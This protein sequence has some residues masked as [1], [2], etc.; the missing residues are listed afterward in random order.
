MSKEYK[1]LLGIGLG[2]VILAVV[3]FKFT[4]QPTTQTPL[5]ERSGT[6]TKG[7]STARV[8]LTEFADFQCPACRSAN[9]LSSQ[10]LAAYPND[11]KFVFRHFPLSGHLNA[12]I[13]AQAAEAAGAQGKFWEMHDLLY[14]KQTE[15]GNTSEPLSRQQAL[16]TFKGYAG[17]LGLDQ[18]AFAQAVENNSSVDVINQDMSA[19]S[20]S[21]VNSTPTFFV[22][23]VMISRPTFDAI[24]A[25]I[26][27][28]LA[29]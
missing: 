2:A 3:L 29:Q 28:A 27:K 15:W 9:D 19:G 8:I 13:S 10:I 20:A 12:M 16:D 21:G 26:D 22:N 24:K 7:S 5:V 25:E 11:V 14:E 23:N 18:S 1:I 4:G 17:Q 6:Y